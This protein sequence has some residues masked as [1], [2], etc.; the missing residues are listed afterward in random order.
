MK[1]ANAIW[2]VKSQLN[3]S[4]SL[5]ALL[6]AKASIVS[7]LLIT[8]HTAYADDRI[9]SSGEIVTSPIALSDGDTLNIQHNGAIT[10]TGVQ[11][12]TGSGTIANITN[13]G[14]VTS[15]GS[16]AFSI[17][18]FLANF[19]NTTSGVIS[20]GSR[21]LFA[22]NIGN[23]TN[24]GV[25]ESDTFGISV[26]NIVNFANSGSIK[27]DTIAIRSA[28]I[29]NFTNSGTIESGGAQAVVMLGIG[30]SNINFN[31][32]SIITGTFYIDGVDDTF[33]FGKGLSAVIKLEN[34]APDV[35]NFSSPI[36]FSDST[37]RAQADVSSMGI[38]G[39]VLADLTNSIGSVAKTRIDLAIL[40]SSNSHDAGY[41]YG[42]R[43]K[44]GH[45][46][47][48]GWGATS[49]KNATSTSA[50][51]S[52]VA[53]GGLVGVDW[54][55][56]DDTLFGMYGGIGLGHI[57]VNVK[58]GQTTDMQNY[59]A[60]TYIAR[61]T[62]IGMLH[63]NTLGGVINF[64][65]DRIT[66]NQTARANYKGYFIAPTLGLTNEMELAGRQVF[67]SVSAGYSGLFLDGYSE[68]GSS[69]NLTVANRNI[70][71]LNARAEVSWIKEISAPD[72]R[73]SKLIPFLGL[74]GSTGV[75]GDDTNISFLGKTTT[76]NP[77]GNNS[78][79]SV[80]AGAKF[81]YE[82][83]D[84]TSVFGRFEASYDTSDTAQAAAQ[85]GLSIK[86]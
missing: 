82:I 55:N 12:V 63:F 86:F 80:F 81:S 74:E 25:I 22:N 30:S 32:G 34:G 51:T 37:T 20:A 67:T 79:G 65:S 68:T 76:F 43:N 9:V 60:G 69:N 35:T 28:T 38:M 36:N 4:T 11:G 54:D 72:G 47:S 7:V 39:D 33:N 52:S 75:G 41:G 57:S 18:G 44:T 66:G 83:S 23:F 3:N 42:V 84:K 15:N 70:H 16:N 13:A 31:A 50:A 6:L 78:V 58:N 49:F 10:V 26:G 61:Q 1:K 27:G 59:T 77:N 29:D 73:K 21:A 17:S 40:G 5:S 85:I 56:G 53:A 2:G 8:T 46:W 64:D 62:D 24:A 45:Y 71:Q 19:N 48:S 14:T